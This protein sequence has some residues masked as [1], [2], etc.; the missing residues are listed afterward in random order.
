[1]WHNLLVNIVA[2]D[3]LLLQCQAT[4]THNTDPIPTIQELRKK[5]GTIINF[6]KWYKFDDLFI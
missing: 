2:A 5:I 4:I 6:E 1:M 3:A